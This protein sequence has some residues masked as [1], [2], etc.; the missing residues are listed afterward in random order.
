MEVG[1]SQLPDEVKMGENSVDHVSGPGDSVLFGVQWTFEVCLLMGTP[2][3]CHA[4]AQEMFP[5]NGV[6]SV[7]QGLEVGWG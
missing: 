2:L 4:A 3:D 6:L 5:T 7:K 1:V